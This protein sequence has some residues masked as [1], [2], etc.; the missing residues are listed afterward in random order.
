MSTLALIAKAPVPGLVKTRL[1]PPCTPHEAAMLAEAALADTLAAM[2]AAAPARLAVVLDGEP[3]P[4]LGEGAEVLSQRGLGLDDR[5]ANA[6]ADLG[7]PALIVG[8][9]TPQVTAGLLGEALAAL[10]HHDAVIG[11]ADDGGYWCIGLRTPDPRALLGVPMSQ[12]TTGAAQRERLAA[13]GLRVAEV[14]ALRDVD[15]FD[16][17]LAVAAAA[18]DTRFARCLSGLPVHA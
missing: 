12:T 10:E 9:D 1:T 7:D 16:A 14:G 5:L 4:W 17:A 6:F 13:L 15:D 11:A 18:P 3:G 8:M 2:R